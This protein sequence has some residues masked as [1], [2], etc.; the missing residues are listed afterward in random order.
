MRPP[1]IPFAY[2]LKKQRLFPLTSSIIP[3]PSLNSLTMNHE[4]FS[5]GFVTVLEQKHNKML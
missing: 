4:P 1:C 2:V 3:L 5:A